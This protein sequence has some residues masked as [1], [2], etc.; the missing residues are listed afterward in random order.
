M[1]TKQLQYS[2]YAPQLKYLRFSSAFFF[3][4]F[5]LLSRY[6]RQDVQLNLIQRIFIYPPQTRMT[7]TQRA[8]FNARSAAL[9]VW[10][11]ERKIS[12]PSRVK[13]LAAGDPLMQYGEMMS[14]RQF[15]RNYICFIHIV[16]F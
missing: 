8:I 12:T 15:S 3:I 2:C 16:F 13:V 10:I 1:E 7:K 11:K 5:L 6:C 9:Y 14:S 4:L